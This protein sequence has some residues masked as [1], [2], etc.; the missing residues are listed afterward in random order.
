MLGGPSI[1][2][3]FGQG[4]QALKKA[5][6]QVIGVAALR[7]LQES[8]SGQRGNW[9]D[10]YSLFGSGKKFL[11]YPE[12]ALFFLRKQY[13]TSPAFRIGEK[14]NPWG[15]PSR[16]AGLVLCGIQQPLKC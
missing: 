11:L 10:I 9:F 7:I 5:G 3:F 1:G 2:L 4:Q 8:S 6:Y 13:R 14:G 16:L 15:V 12:L